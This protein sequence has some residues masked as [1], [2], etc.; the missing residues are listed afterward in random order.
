MIL[1]GLCKKLFTERFPCVTH[2]AYEDHGR[3]HIIRLSDVL[4]GDADEWGSLEREHRIYSYLLQPLSKQMDCPRDCLLFPVGAS[5]I[6]KNILTSRTPDCTY[7]VG[8]S[9]LSSEGKVGPDS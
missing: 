7:P 6:V 8:F 4:T 2:V 5:S 9:F 1:R 3:Y